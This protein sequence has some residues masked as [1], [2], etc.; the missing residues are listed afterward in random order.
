MRRNIT[1][2]L[3]TQPELSIEA[4]LAR[5]PIQTGTVELLGYLQIAHE[6]GH[7]IDRSQT[8][9]L[10]THWEGAQARLLRMPRVIF[11]RPQRSASAASAPDGE[12]E[13]G[14]NKASTAAV[15]KKSNID[16]EVFN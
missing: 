3:Q 11:R 4:L 1:L 7:V 14:P 15:A 8:I 12:L 6:D 10:T 5:F 2:A 13:N 16:L 9:E